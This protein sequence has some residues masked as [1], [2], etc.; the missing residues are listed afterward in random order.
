MRITPTTS[1]YDGKLMEETVREFVETCDAVITMG[2]MQTDF[3]TGAFT[4][5]LDPARTIDIGLHRTTVGSTVYQ[6]VEMADIANEL[7]GR[8]WSAREPARIRPTS[9]GSVAGSDADPISADAL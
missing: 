6:N 3:N 4:A 7:A 5:H 2:T 9:L 1:A 8:T